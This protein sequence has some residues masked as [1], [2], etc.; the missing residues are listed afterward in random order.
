[1]LEMQAYNFPVQDMLRLVI[2]KACVNAEA[3]RMIRRIWSEKHIIAY[4]GRKFQS[5]CYFKCDSAHSE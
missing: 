5:V 4:F 3:S 1:M 2:G